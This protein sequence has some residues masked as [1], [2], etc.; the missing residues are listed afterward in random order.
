MEQKIN[1]QQ[2]RIAP[3]LIVDILRILIKNKIGY[4]IIGVKARTNV[5]LLEA[6][7]APANKM[8]LAAQDNIEAMLEDYNHYLDGLNDTLFADE[9]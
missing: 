3:E 7:F 6:D 5:I 8:H 1:A 2:Y 9:D 4:E